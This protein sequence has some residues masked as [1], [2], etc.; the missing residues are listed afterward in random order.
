MFQ[1][2]LSI[3]SNHAQK[4]A[5]LRV[6]F[7]EENSKLIVDIAG[8]IAASLVKGG[9]ILIC[10]NGGSAADA[11]H[12]AAEFVGRF[13][14]E[15]PALPAIA[16]TTD[17]SILTAVSNDYNFKDI[18]K[19]QIKAL[20]KE[21]D[22]LI[23]ISTSGKS[24][25]IIEAIEAAKEKNMLTVGLTGKKGLP[26]L[27]VCDYVLHVPSDETPLIQEIH[28]S[29]LHIICELVDVFLFEEVQ[30]LDLYT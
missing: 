14:L 13:K 8:Y 12:M 7:F 9:K 26:M 21:G 28:I 29:A 22:I 11:Q 16:L 1:K 30:K 19:R 23:A 5:E 17:T 2:E 3:I 4:G 27:D 24:K 6:L 15:R 10:G 18:F 25:N 20:G